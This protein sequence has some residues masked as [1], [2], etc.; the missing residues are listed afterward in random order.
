M[1]DVSVNKI[2]EQESQKKYAE[3]L[4]PALVATKKPIVFVATKCDYL[5]REMLNYL[6]QIATKKKTYQ[7]VETSMFKGINTD[8]PFLL[9]ANQTTKRFGH[10]KNLTYSEALVINEQ[11]V[12]EMMTSFQSYI[13]N[14]VTDFR[15]KVAQIIPKI[16]SDP[17][18][19]KYYQFTY[20]MLLYRRS[21]SFAN[22]KNLLGLDI[23]IIKTGLLLCVCVCLFVCPDCIKEIGE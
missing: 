6:I 12:E 22:P 7:I 18:F 9:L 1:F 10:I 16:K 13:D 4:L 11:S 20:C 21:K 17:I 19:G 23:Y 5:D 2:A 15:L 14:E 3:R 8:I